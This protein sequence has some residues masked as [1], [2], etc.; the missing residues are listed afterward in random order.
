[1][2]VVSVAPLELLIRL[3]TS[4]LRQPTDGERVDAWA[5]SIAQWRRSIP[6]LRC[7]VSSLPGYID[8]GVFLTS[9]HLVDEH[10]VRVFVIWVAA[11]AMPF[12]VY[13]QLARQGVCGSDCC[14]E[15]TEEPNLDGWM[16]D[17]QC[18]DDVLARRG[19]F[20]DVR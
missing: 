13:Q 20:R 8:C 3:L 1:M 18:R 2:D 16:K 15:C 19:D 12:S 7:A 17:M 11:E 6:D 10:C 5:V 9:T 4:S 14:Y